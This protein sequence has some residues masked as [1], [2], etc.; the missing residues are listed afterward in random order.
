MF[1]IKMMEKMN[2]GGNELT[3][4]HLENDRSNG[5]CIIP[6]NTGEAEAPAFTM[7]SS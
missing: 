4:V 6:M 1:R 2:Q 7:S 3:Q 5:I